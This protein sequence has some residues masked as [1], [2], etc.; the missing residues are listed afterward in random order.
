[1]AD[2]V[3]PEQSDPTAQP[4]DQ[5]K[6]SGAGNALTQE[7]KI[8]GKTLKKNV[9]LTADELAEVNSKKGLLQLL[10][11]K[12]V[13]INKALI[14]LRYEQELEKLQIELVKLQR[15]VQL[16]GRRV[17]IIFEG[18]DAAGK[19]GS[20]RRFIEHL[21]PRSARVVALPKPT[22]VQRG[23]WYFQ[24]YAEQLPNPGEV[25]F[26]DRSWYNRAVVEP[27]MN[28]CTQDQYRVFMQQVPEFEHML[29]EDN[30]E[31]CEILVLD[32][33]RS[34]TGAL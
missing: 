19:G 23:Q 18:R 21:N 5:E 22:E 26:F 31:N 16:Q 14:K 8:V 17:A 2:D 15:T 10:S 11:T 33:Q 20:I 6:R 7:E 24:R 4:V 30:L 25:V 3:L 13:N 12:N 28:F 32:L 34:A 27:V 29:Y 9:E 1:M